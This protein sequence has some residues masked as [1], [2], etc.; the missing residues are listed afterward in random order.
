MDCEHTW[1]EEYYGHRCVICD[2]F[3]PHGSE[4]WA[5][6]DEIDDPSLYGTCPVCAGEFGDGWTNCTCGDTEVF[7]L[8]GFYT[9]TPNGVTGHVHG[10]PHMS[11]ETLEALHALMDA[12]VKHV[13]ST[14][15]TAQTGTE[16]VN[17][18]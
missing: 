8:H 13:G 15:G 17:G 12:A 18:K 1:Q 10:D 16:L 14:G 4:P 3:A 2:A 6:P 7:E 9:T 11:A 5:E